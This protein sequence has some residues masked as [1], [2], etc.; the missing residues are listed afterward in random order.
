MRWH[1][2]F[3]IA[4]QERILADEAVDYLV[5]EDDHKGAKESVQTAS[6]TTDVTQPVHENVDVAL[7]DS[8]V[9]IE[10][11]SYRELN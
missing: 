11:E 2:F 8:Q 1:S 3:S 4:N 6:E 7:Y 5:L 10:L 9:T